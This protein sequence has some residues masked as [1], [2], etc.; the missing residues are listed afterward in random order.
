[1]NFREK[2][3]IDGKGFVFKAFKNGKEKDRTSPSEILE[4]LPA[5]SRFLFDLI[6]IQMHS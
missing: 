3:R 2:N 1:M 6:A 4:L 5:R